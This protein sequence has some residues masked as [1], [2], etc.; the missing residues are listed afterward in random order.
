MSGEDDA[1]AGI[2]D[3]VF[4]MD[5]D[6]DD[7]DDLAKEVGGG[8]ASDLDEV[9]A[10][11]LRSVDTRLI[12]Q[13]WGFESAKS[14]E[15]GK[16]DQSMLNHVR[17]AV[18]F[19]HQLAKQ[20]ETL[21]LRD[22]SAASLR[23]L[24]ALAV[25]HD[26]HKLRVEDD[27]PDER[28]DI[29]EEE[30]RE[31]VQSLGLAEFTGRDGD[32]LVIEDFHS[33]VIDH[34]NSQYANP[35]RVTLRWEEEYRPLIRLAD[36]M[37]SAS[38]PTEAVSEDKQDHAF[39][40]SYDLQHHCFDKTTGVL[41][42]FINQAVADTLSE[43]Y[44]YA[45]LTIYTD[46]CVYVA[47]ADSDQPTADDGFIDAVYDAT[48]ASIRETH[49][50]YETPHTVADTL[51]V[52]SGKYS[53]SG[54]H[55]LY[56]GAEKVVQATVLNGLAGSVDDDPT[57]AGI[58]NIRAMSE[59][60][61]IEIG[62]TRHIYELA[63]L[64]YTIQSE[65]IKKPAGLDY[66][67]SSVTSIQLTGEVLGLPQ[68]AIDRACDVSEADREAMQSG[69]KWDIGYALAAL[70]TN[71]YG[72]PEALKCQRE[73]LAATIVDGLHDL[74]IRKYAIAPD[75]DVA[76]VYQRISETHSGD[77][78]DELKSYIGEYLRV[79]REAA[80]EESPVTDTYKQYTRKNRGKICSI[81]SHGSATA[82]LTEMKATEGDTNVR[83]GFTTRKAISSKKEQRRVICLPCQ[84]E[85]ALR[86]DVADAQDAQQ[87]YLHLAPDYFYTPGLWRLYS[88]LIG[89]FGT[90]SS[91][92]MKRLAEA[93]HNGGTAEEY[94]DALDNL[95]HISTDED[96]ANGRS[97]LESR[98]TEYDASNHFGSHVIGYHKGIAD[99]NMNDTQQQFFG[100]YL[101]A[102]ISSYTGLRVYLSQ[103]PIAEIQ[104]DEYDEFVKLGG[105]PQVKS[106]HGDAIPL[107][108]LKDVIDT[109][110]ALIVLGYEQQGDERNDNLFAK[111]LRISR[112]S[113][114]PGSYFLKRFVQEADP[115]EGSDVHFLMEYAETLDQYN[116]SRVII[117]TDS[118]HM[119]GDN[120]TIGV[121]EQ[122][123]VESKI[124]RLAELAFDAIRP[125]PGSTTPHRVERVFRE[126]VE[127][128][129]DIQTD[130]TVGTEDAINAV[131]GQLIKMIE[132]G[133]SGVYPVNSD[134]TD[135][136]GDFKARVKRY[137][138]YFV[139]EMLN[140]VAGGNPSELNR[141][142][143][144]YANAFY[145]RTLSLM[146][147]QQHD[148]NGDADADKES[149]ADEN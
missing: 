148:N 118:R 125:K 78:I 76:A 106:F 35:D 124:T 54:S 39:P 30:V 133:Q 140:D 91:V 8:S 18:F 132:R 26:L 149:E 120:T 75:P 40:A 15:Y 69:G 127:A 51:S 103:S 90:A 21:S 52:A 109:A 49:P 36:G 2:P 41:T 27:N 131:Y 48:T 117:T 137:A 88:R 101:A 16:T 66:N 12:D 84:I 44:G 104:P 147:E 143:N 136:D 19:L 77:Y 22:I 31:S 59:A 29:P 129:T 3:S 98:F 64:I 14:V 146:E 113:V 105:F 139:E 11:Y 85:Q 108:G 55:F 100:A 145:G 17:N 4:S 43:R 86:G 46:G 122:D 92:R 119:L 42:N 61:G 138:E 65:L 97:M 123:D 38:T 53:L 58:E 96:E 10:D 102:T 115:D 142:E 94:H 128:V 67:N 57:D 130:G 45:L 60:T 7:D 73:E 116:P 32:Q 23:D 93:V 72:G 83:V 74:Y 47:P 114:L 107:S 134:K 71:E 111:Y 89:R 80:P 5:G 82:N 112:K 62:E 95:T 13:G 121:G 25:I 37:A 20:T 56:A 63:R 99:D 110:S 68:D 79:G 126:S 33:C 28:F 50:K 141:L 1:L 24:T 70:L 6:D 135:A 81:C 34:H 144:D 87:F 9:V